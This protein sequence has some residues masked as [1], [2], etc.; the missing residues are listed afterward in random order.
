[1][2]TKARHQSLPTTVVYPIKLAQRLIDDSLNKKMWTMI[3]NQN[4]IGSIRSLEKLFKRSVIPDINHLD[5]DSDETPLTYAIW[6]GYSELVTFLLENNADIN[7]PNRFGRTALMYACRLTG[8]NLPKLLIDRGAN[9]NAKDC[10]G[11]PAL[12]R[13]AENNNTRLVELLVAVGADPPPFVYTNDESA[14]QEAVKTGKKQRAE[15]IKQIRIQ[16]EQLVDFYSD[17]AEIIAEYTYGP[18]LQPSLVTHKRIA[19]ARFH[20]PCG[21]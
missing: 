18:F 15:S 11:N 16:V 5:E 21:C 1:M 8:T 13:A 9:V 14:F 6:Y 7:A 10:L 3:C 17:L 4:R 19:S 12:L 2:S 20:C